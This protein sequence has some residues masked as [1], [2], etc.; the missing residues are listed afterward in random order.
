MSTIGQVWYLLQQDTYDFS[1]DL[2]EAYLHIPPFKHFLNFCMV[3]FATETFSVE[4][5]EIGLATAPSFH[6]TY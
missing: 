2:K 5:F 4:G 3:S 6:F 1:I